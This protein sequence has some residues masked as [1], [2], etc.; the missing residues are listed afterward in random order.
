VVAQY[1]ATGHFGAASRVPRVRSR[2]GTDARNRPL[3]VLGAHPTALSAYSG[4]TQLPS[5]RQN[6]MVENVVDWQKPTRSYAV[7]AAVLWA[8]T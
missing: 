2:L 1:G 5:R 8:L 7:R 6:M 3:G 4:R